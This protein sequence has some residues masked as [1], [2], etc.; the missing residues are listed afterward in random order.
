M[1][2]SSLLELHCALQQFKKTGFVPTVIPVTETWEIPEAHTTYELPGYRYIG[3]PIEQS[4]LATRGV[5]GTG[6][7]I[8]EEFFP[9]CSVV[10]VKRNH[11]DIMWIQLIDSTSTTYVAVV[12]S[13]PK[14][15]PNHKAIMAALQHQSNTTTPSSHQPGES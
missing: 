9:Q 4:P 11:K 12:Y 15:I 14:D 8:K 13:H 10:P 7:W 5:G 1:D 3:K 6:I 2:D